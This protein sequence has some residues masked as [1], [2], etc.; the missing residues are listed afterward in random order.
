MG[1]GFSQMMK[2][3]KQAA[4][5]WR[6]ALGGNRALEDAL[7]YAQQRRASVSDLEASAVATI[8]PTWQ[9]NSRPHAN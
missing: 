5:K 1:E 2:G 6:R 9:P 7:A 8:W 3:S 4:S